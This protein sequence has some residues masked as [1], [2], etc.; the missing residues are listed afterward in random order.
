MLG[1]D[2]GIRRLSVINMWLAIGLAL[3]VFAVGPTL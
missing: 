3:F 2:A 1:V